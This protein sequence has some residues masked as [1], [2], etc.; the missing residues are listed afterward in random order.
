MTTATVAA[1]YGIV[2]VFLY[3]LSRYPAQAPARTGSGEVLAATSAEGAD[4]RR[5][6]HYPHCAAVKPDFVRLRLTHGR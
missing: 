1:A 3:A 4:W 2:A 6:L 5:R